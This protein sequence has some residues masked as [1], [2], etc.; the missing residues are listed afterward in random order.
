[1]KDLESE[2][3]DL[4]KYRENY[5]KKNRGERLSLS[6]IE[7][8]E[9]IDCLSDL[10]EELHVETT[11]PLRSS[12]DP[13][14][15]VTNHIQENSKTAEHYEKEIEQL[16]GKNCNIATVTEVVCLFLYACLLRFS[17]LFTCNSL[18]HI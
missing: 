17:L 8:Q 12:A 2:V 15:T 5:E 6:D 4:R 10:D 11:T 3:T 16:Q 1:M 7:T 18:K 13:D 9:V 14:E